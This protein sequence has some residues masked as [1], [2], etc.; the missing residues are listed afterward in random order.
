M[1]LSGLSVQERFKMPNLSGVAKESDIFK[2]MEFF[3]E[4][5][6]P[7]HPT[8]ELQKCVAAH[9]GNVVVSYTNHN[10]TIVCHKIKH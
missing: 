8:L 4:N 10:A 6:S 5:G 1:P 2:G 7:L 3:I 9:G